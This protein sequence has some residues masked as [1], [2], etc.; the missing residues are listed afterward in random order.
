MLSLL[1]R[2][3]ATIVLA[4]AATI[5]MRLTPVVLSLVP[6]GSVIRMRLTLAVLSLVSTRSGI[7]AWLML[8]VLPLMPATSVLI[9]SS[10]STLKQYHW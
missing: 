3:T 10:M 9:V 6:T 2:T 8:E 7:L 4:V 1:K 5:R